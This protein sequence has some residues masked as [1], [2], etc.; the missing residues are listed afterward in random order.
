VTRFTNSTL[1]SR[2]STCPCHASRMNCLPLLFNGG[3]EGTFGGRATID[4][5]FLTCCDSHRQNFAVPTRSSD[6]SLQT[7]R[8]MHAC[9]MAGSSSY[10]FLTRVA[11]RSCSRAV[12]R[13]STAIGGYCCKAS[14]LASSPVRFG[15][16]ATPCP[17]GGF[18]VGLSVP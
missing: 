10:R 9:A 7:G 16:A 6:D 3:D 15:G 4:L 2:G 11:T 13:C 1:T 5:N 14:L 12:R 18:E 17:T 8:C